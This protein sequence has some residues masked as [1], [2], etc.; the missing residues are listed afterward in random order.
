LPTNPYEVLAILESENRE[1]FTGA[2]AMILDRVKRQIE[3][4]SE[5]MRVKSMLKGG[6][7]NLGKIQR[8]AAGSNDPSADQN[9]Q[10]TKA[11]IIQQLIESTQK[12]VEIAGE[13]ESPTKV[14]GRIVP[15]EV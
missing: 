12:E 14:A 8:A 15:V 13:A 5:E 2:K 3:N 6:F 10:G 1:I 4:H 7:A 9:T 11:D